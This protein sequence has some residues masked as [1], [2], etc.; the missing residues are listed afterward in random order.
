MRFAKGTSG[1]I[2]GRPKK[3]PLSTEEIRECIKQTLAGLTK[4]LS[5]DLK[6]LKPKD[7]LFMFER[8]LKF[9]LPSPEFDLGKL[10][11]KDL[12]LLIEKLREKSMKA[13]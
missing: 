7:R 3:K 13:A 2:K 5:R 6:S 4:D 10:S 12:D 8:L 9:V 11:D 1:N